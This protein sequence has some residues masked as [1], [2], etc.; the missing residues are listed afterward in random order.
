MPNG[1]RKSRKA[2]AKAPPAKPGELDKLTTFEIA[3]YEGNRKTLSVVSKISMPTAMKLL[4]LA[5][6][7]SKAKGGHDAP[8]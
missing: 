1:K 6:K 7:E 5:N 3:S 2:N 4:A 8:R